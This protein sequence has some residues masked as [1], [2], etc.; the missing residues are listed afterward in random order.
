MSSTKLKAENAIDFIKAQ[1]SQI[2]RLGLEIDTL[3]ETIAKL[4]AEL[5]TVKT[6]NDSL[7]ETHAKTKEKLDETLGMIDEYV[8]LYNRYEDYMSSGQH[9]H[10]SKKSLN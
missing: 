3:K 8:D 1:D 2:K 6:V 7:R 4:Q 10:S 9:I 5:S